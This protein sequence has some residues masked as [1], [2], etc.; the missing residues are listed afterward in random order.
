MTTGKCGSEIIIV[1]SLT[2]SDLGLFAAHRS[3]ANSKQ[4]AININSDKARRLLSPEA[5][6]NGGSDLNCICVY[7]DKVIREP[8]RLGK[9]GKNWR[10][11]GKKIEG[12]AFAELDSKDLVL[13]RSSAPNNGTQPVT[14]LFVSKTRNRVVHAGLVAIVERQLD[15][16]MAVFEEGGDGFNALAEHCPAMPWR[17]SARKTHVSS[18]RIKAR[19]VPPMPD[20]DIGR[21]HRPKTVHE[22]IRSPHILE[23][24]LKVAGDMSAPAQLRFLATVDKLATQLREILLATDRIVPLEKN[25]QGFW[26]SVSGQRMGFIDGGLANLSMLGSAPIAARVGGYTVIPGVRGPERENFTVLKCLIDEL[27]AHD[28]GGV[29]DNSFPDI[30]ALRDAARISIEAAGAVRLLSDYPD[31]KWLLLHGALVNP[32]SRYSDV[33]KD[34][35]TRFQFPGF[36]SA[37][38]ERFLS[39]AEVT[40]SGR[41]RNFISVHLKQLQLLEASN[42]VVCGVIERESTTTSVCRAL[43]DSFSDDDIRDL[44]PEP[45]SEWKKWFRG[46]TDPSGDDDFEGQRITDSLLFRCVL[47]PG[48]AILPVVIDRN[49]MR[50]A[51]DAWKREISQYPKPLV[52]Y[53]K[54]TEWNAPIR[55]EIF[56][57]DRAIFNELAK[58]ILH[59]SLLLP[60]YAFPVGLDIVDKFARIPDWMSRPINTHTAVRAMRA[61]LDNGDERLFDTLRR[62]LCGSGREF[63]LRPGIFR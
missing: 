34:G 56:E 35:R 18:E 39:E 46:A 41:E 11:G 59:C 32:V 31:T 38:I 2:E 4:R 49:E 40:R 20:E 58:L 9:T 14:V 1:R 7:G 63:L 5:F 16:S 36:S 62:M 61:A 28:E 47:E 30:G 13:I 3:S 6:A 10:L 52:S 17:V 53:L 44:L 29:Y 24:M 8:R 21:A 42:A 25:H 57:K 51:P 19:P 55:I 43:L 37:A 33:M 48:E 15:G 60:R 54:A 45:P 26:A 50:R 23:H 12:D 27:Y 22:K